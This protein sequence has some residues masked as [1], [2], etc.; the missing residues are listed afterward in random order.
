MDR[1]PCFLV[2]VIDIHR[3]S[4][5]VFSSGNDLC[6]LLEIAAPV[7]IPDISDDLFKDVLHCEHAGSRTVF[8]KNDRDGGCLLPHFVQK[9]GNILLLVGIVRLFDMIGQFEIL[10]IHKE[11]GFDVDDPYDIVISVFVDRETR[12]AVFP[13]IIDETVV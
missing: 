6:D 1:Q 8:V 4:A 3:S 7:I 11:H 13:E 9:V 5:G 10:L 2:E 12:I